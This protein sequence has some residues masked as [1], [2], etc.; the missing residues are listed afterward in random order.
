MKGMSA[1]SR[2]S[3]GLV[4][5]ITT[6]LMVGSYLG[7]IPDTEKDR[8]TNRAILAETIAIFSSGLVDK[9]SPKRIE[10]DFSLLVERNDD[11]VSIGLRPK[12]GTLL[13]ATEKHKDL[14]KE[15]SGV[16][17]TDSQLRVPI[18]T[19]TDE[20]GQLE[21]RFV[22]ATSTILWGFFDNSLVRIVFFISLLSFA[23]FYF[24]LGKV[25]RQLDPSQ[26]IPGRVKAALDTMAEGLLILDRKEQVVLANKAF[27]DIFAK[28]PN[29]LLGLKASEFSWKNKEGQTITQEQRPWIK[30]LTSGK[31]IKDEMLALEFEE[32]LQKSFKVNCS[33]VLGE[34]KKYAGVLVGFD[35]ITLLE[36]KETELRK[37]KEEAE[38]ANKAKSAFLANMS[39]EIRTPMNA[40]L[41][42]T[43]ILK[44]G[45]VKNE[46]E[47]LKYLNTIHSSGKS[48]LELINDILDLSKVEAG[49]LEFE[50]VQFQPYNTIDDVVEMLRPTAEKKGIALSWKA[51]EDIPET[52]LGDPMRF[53]QILFNLIGN[54][55]K[56]TDQGSV[57]VEC[58]CSQDKNSNFLKIDI[59]D[60][61]IGMSETVLQ[62]VFDP[63]VQADV[64]VSRRFGG[65]GLG[66]SISRKFA[67]ALGGDITV[68]SRENKGSVFSVLMQTGSALPGNLISPQTIKALCDQY[69]ESKVST[70]N[71]T[72]GG[73]VLVVDDGRE[74]RELVKIILEEA[75][76]SVDE[77]ENGA[78]GVEK[79]TSIRYDLILMD[80]QMPVMD[81]FTAAKTM[82]KSG[83]TQPIIAL[84]ANAMQGFE[85]Q[86]LDNGYSDYATK[87]VDIDKLIQIV[88]KYLQADATS[89]E[90]SKVPL[91]AESLPPQPGESNTKPSPA[92]ISRFADH[93]KLKVVVQQFVDKLAGEVQALNRAHEENDYLKLATLAHWLKGAAGTVGFDEFTKPAEQLEIVA[94]TK[95]RD[96]VA[97]LLEHINNLQQRTLATVDTPPAAILPQELQTGSSETLP[98]TPITSRLASHPQLKKVVF[99]FITKVP[100]EI[101]KMETA[102][103]SGDFLQ[104]EHLAHWLKG[105]AGTV[106]FD[107]F[108]R[109]A[110]ELEESAK[111]SDSLKSS[112]IVE[113][114]KI[115]VHNIEAPR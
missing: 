78:I 70:W 66:L 14:W 28:E 25:L 61:G 57:Q 9:A 42:F 8:R 34:N 92:V 84:T 2:V 49:K 35:D 51:I 22:N 6:I 44:R 110:T 104:L 98:N 99:D 91:V 72:G 26:A 12:N 37:S 64:T 11:L 105:A 19:G 3:L 23:V 95:N 7:I 62:N 103:A 18:S 54:A 113:K 102:L 55:I 16:N 63:F 24:Y 45:Y 108:T 30:A 29:E 40:I 73:R 4:G 10:D 107:D 86:C 56:F 101:S 60:S 33:P 93:P 53:R 31:I 74:N 96:K 111:S 1:K 85:Q 20:W 59:I 5:I 115:M 80:V 94:R 79:A 112:Y 38:E 87:P 71:F 27:A 50:S 109:P 32:G 76:L 75:G 97:A 47:S 46:Q 100:D 65:T 15:M 67:R 114:I 13:C 58:S 77:A 21:L 82:R 48:L 89:Q 17:S 43:D 81:G 90:T 88:K 106:G 83:L 36:K 68:T 39:H 69:V 52:I 41:G